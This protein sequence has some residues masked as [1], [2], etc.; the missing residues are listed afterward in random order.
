MRIVKKIDRLIQLM[1]KYSTVE[2]RQKAMSLFNK[3][4][5]VLTHKEVDML[6]IELLKNPF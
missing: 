3:D 6:E 5:K 1:Y 2:L 4:W